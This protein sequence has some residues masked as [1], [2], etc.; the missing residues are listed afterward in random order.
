MRDGAGLGV[1]DGPLM[2]ERARGA[3]VAVQARAIGAA[4]LLTCAE[5]PADI[6]FNRAFDVD[7]REP[8]VTTALVDRARALGRRPLLEIAAGFDRRRGA[9][10]TARAGTCQALER[11][12]PPPRSGVLRSRA[13]RAGEG[14]Q[15]EPGRGRSLRRRRRAG[16]R[17]SARGDPRGEHR[18]RGAYVDGGGRS[19]TPCRSRGPAGPRATSSTGSRSPRPWGPA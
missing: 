18:S 4:T 6:G 2:V 7:A 9:R 3:G 5:F 16:L 14:P 11:G 17:S 8:G 13:A 12:R 15:R 1:R 19:P 10:A